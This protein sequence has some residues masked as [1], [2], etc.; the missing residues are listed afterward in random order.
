M[1]LYQTWKDIKKE[2]LWVWIYTIVM[3]VVLVMLLLQIDTIYSIWRKNL[4][5]YQF[6]Q[7]NIYCT[8]PCNICLQKDHETNPL[9]SDD[10]LQSEQLG[11]FCILTNDDYSNV[12]DTYYYIT[13]LTGCYAKKMGLDYGNEMQCYVMQKNDEQENTLLINGTPVPLAGEVESKFDIFHPTIYMGHDDEILQHSVILCCK[14]IATLKELFPFSFVEDDILNTLILENPTEEERAY[15]EQALYQS[16]GNYFEFTPAKEYAKHSIKSVTK[17]C[18]FELLFLAVTMLFLLRLL[19]RNVQ[20]MIERKRKEY[21]IHYLY[22][23]PLRMIQMRAGGFILFL[24]I[25]PCLGML[26]ELQKNY[27]YFKQYACYLINPQ[28]AI[29]FFAIVVFC[30]IVLYF[31]LFRYVGKLMT[32]TNGLGDLR[33]K[34]DANLIS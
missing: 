29:Y 15:F 24:H 30:L 16:Y 1:V 33:R 11:G 14:N 8:T 6:Q 2:G 25:I 19:F 9:I 18:L 28:R 17:S 27:Y 4:H 7:N 12:D 10:V 23:E 20:H 22:G 31:Y 34:R 5:L 21:L 13:I 3:T 32:E 26:Y